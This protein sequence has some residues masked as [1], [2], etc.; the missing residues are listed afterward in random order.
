M[1][2][3]VLKILAVGMSL[4]AAAGNLVAQV[5]L[6]TLHSFSGYP[7]DG[8]GPIGLVQGSD[9]NFYGTT[10]YGGTFSGDGTA[11]QMT[12]NGAV[13]I[14][15]SFGLSPDGV[16][17]DAVL[18]QGSDGKF[19]G[20]TYG[21]GTNGAGTVFQ[22]TKNG[23]VTLLH[24]FTNTPDGAVPEG[25]LVQ[26]SDGNF[27][28]TTSEGGKR[29]NGAV[30]QITTN[31]TLTILHSFT[32]TV[33][34]Y[35]PEGELV[36]GGD[37]NFYGTTANGGTN[38]L[39]PGYG[40]VFR[41]ATNGTLT[42]LHSFTNS[43]DGSFPG[44][45]LV[46]G[47]DGNFYG[48]TSYGGTNG[49]GTIFRISTNGT[50][51]ILH[52]FTNTPDGAQPNGLVLGSDGNFYGTTDNGGTNNLGT[53]FQM[54][55]NG[56]LTILHSFTDSPEGANP[57]GLAQGS[58]GNFYGTTAYGGTNKV[59]ENGLIGLGTVFKLVVP[60][61]LPA[62]QISAIQIAGTNVLV[63]IPSVAAEIYQLQYRTLLT[64]GAWADVAGASATSIGGSLT[65]TNLGGF[66]QSQ[67][68]YR[69]A[70]TP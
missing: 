59:S 58:D 44:E 15:H 18:V 66:S 36:Q 31:G 52:S 65:M 7:F 12:T 23:T 2:A 24:S 56:T 26:G 51:T 5:T 70:I 53:V 35:V 68:F 13:T 39:F 8:E 46:Q 6:T 63:T 1:N 41:I 48:T 55:T 22:I 50:L 60:L 4:C 32:N 3:R 19:Y 17:P 57:T 10:T 27:Y 61:N 47:T 28:G 64:A 37:G 29:D 30:F 34:G 43:P 14:L 11:F 67:Q 40:T 69:F 38:N 20:T 49:Y 33:G 25:G 45:G 54:T 21:G 62:N 9:G 16:N 42:I